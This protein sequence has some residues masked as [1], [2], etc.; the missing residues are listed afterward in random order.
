M[1][2]SLISGYTWKLKQ[3]NYPLNEKDLEF[4]GKFKFEWEQI[5]WEHIEKYKKILENKKS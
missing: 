4:L 2:D 3:N 5:F 1:V